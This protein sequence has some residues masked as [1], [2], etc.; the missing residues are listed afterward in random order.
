MSQRRF[1][2]FVVIVVVLLG[3]FVLILFLGRSREYVNKL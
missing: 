2:G 1:L 3:F